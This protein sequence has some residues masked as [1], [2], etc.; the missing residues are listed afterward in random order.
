M[1]WQASEANSLTVQGDYYGGKE[2]SRFNDSFTLGTIPAGTFI[3]DAD[4]GGG[5]VL[6]RWNRDAGDGRDFALQVYYD[7]TRRDIPSTYDEARDTL[8]IDFQRHHLLEQRHDLLWGAG[9][10]ETADD[11]GNTL[12]A[13]F[14]PASRTDHT[15]SA[16]LQDKITVG[17]RLYLTVGSK[18]E[19]NDYTGFESQPNVRV[20]WLIDDRRT[21][22]GAVSQ[23]VRVSSR[24]D[25]DLR[26]TL[27]LDVPSLPFPVYV[28]VAGNPDLRAENLIA[29][30]AGYRVVATTKLSF[31]ATVFRQD[32]TH[33]QTVEPQPPVILPDPNIPYALV[34]NVLEDNMHGRSVGA[35]LSANW[36]PASRVRL[37]FQY[38]FLDLD[39][40]AEAGSLDVERPQLAGNSPRHQVSAQAFVD[41]SQRLSLFSAARYV[42]ELPHQAVPSYTAVDLSLRWRPAEHLDA[43]LTVQNLTDAHHFEFGSGGA[44]QIERSTVLRAAWT[45]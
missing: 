16:F 1:D 34:P 26:L 6:A 38:A 2:T 18:F 36:Q 11:I 31:D 45:F 41:L 40:A 12:F 21:F 33:L 3:D 22:W 14:V 29:Y 24:L 27:P 20:S 19:H 23:A 8:D 39:L 32:Y 4:I 42:D 5:N 7:H 30:E 25:S 35:T 10:R 9:F 28:T 15:L 43:S 17:Q 13:T 37:R 44:S